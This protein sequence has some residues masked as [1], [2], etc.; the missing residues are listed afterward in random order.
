MIKFAL[1]GVHGS[2]KTTLLSRIERKLTRRGI[3]CVHV[4][5]VAQTC[6]IQT[7]TDTSFGAQTWIFAEQI[8]Q[9]TLAGT[10]GA[11]VVLCDRTLLDNVMYLR[12]LIDSEKEDFNHILMM[13][14]MHRM[15]MNWASTYDYIVRLK[16]NLPWVLKRDHD[17]GTVEE[18]TSFAKTIESWFNYWESEYVDV[19][20]STVPTARDMADIIEKRLER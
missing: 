15:A 17:K 7:G 14:S 9:E 13:R 8:Q 12:R 1:T 2:G 4:A 6:P 16:L 11:Q 18:L 20:Y 10:F 19:A 3:S 5:E